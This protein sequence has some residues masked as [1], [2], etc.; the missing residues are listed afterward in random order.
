MERNDCDLDKGVIIPKQL[1]TTAA[2]LKL[3][4]SRPQL[5]YS[6]SI[7][8]TILNNNLELCSLKRV[9]MGGVAFTVNGLNYCFFTVYG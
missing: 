1:S 7:I 2:P 5:S 4:S 8:L 3:S 6:S 9:S